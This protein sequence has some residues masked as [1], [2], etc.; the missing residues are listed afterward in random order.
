M[1]DNE[2]INLF[3]TDWFKKVDSFS[4]PGQNMKLY[5]ENMK[6]TQTGLGKL[7][8]NIPR[9]NIS[10]ME[11]N[12]RGISKDIAKKLSRIFKVPI[13]RFI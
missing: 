2:Y 8:G 12:K 13:E 7:L 1:N 3:E 6:L 10:S 9:Q 5:R 11:R 4:S